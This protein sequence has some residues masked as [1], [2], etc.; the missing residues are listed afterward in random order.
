MN[1]LL[2]NGQ[3]ISELMYGFE[4]SQATR[5]Q[6]ITNNQTEKGTFFVNIKPID[7]FGFAD[8]VKVT[9]GLS[10]TPTLERNKNNDPIIR[11]AGVDAG[12]KNCYKRYWLVYSTFYT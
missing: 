4:E 10:Y 7:L 12:C 5:R 1:K 9:Y 8:Q 3:H 2:T 11:T 6:K